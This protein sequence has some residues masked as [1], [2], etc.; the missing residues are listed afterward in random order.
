MNLIKD[1]Q[2]ILDPVKFVEDSL[3][4][5]LDDWQRDVLRFEGRQ[6]AMCCSRQS[7]K[8]T[9]AALKALY[10]AINFPESLTL[11]VS[12]SQRQSSEMFRLVTKEMR[13][14]E[15]QPQKVE[16]NKLSMTLQTG[17]RVVSL[18]SHEAT[19]RGYSKPRLILV[20]EAARC[21]D[22]LYLAIRPM[23]ATVETGQLVV[24]STP[25][26]RQGFFFEIFESDDDN[27]KRIKI[28]ATQCPRIT[29][30]FLKEEK[31]TLGEF[32][33]KQEY[34]NEFVEGENAV[35]RYSDIMRCFK[36]DVKPINLWGDDDNGK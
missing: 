16:D 8:S 35:F 29:P 19:V 21:T 15:T 9:I 3:L 34:M 31:E 26:G 6:L 28:D 36:P 4:Y 1:V 12:P 20:D 24:L 27:W 14:L 17:S 32:F 25:N 7:G 30:E 22:S 23:L 10:T 13:K 33:F 5:S 2:H 11:I 18:P